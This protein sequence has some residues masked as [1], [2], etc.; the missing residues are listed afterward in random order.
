MLEQERLE[1]EAQER[2][3]YER[4]YIA[5][6]EKQ[7]KLLKESQNL[8]RLAKEERKCAP[9]PQCRRT[10]SEW[11]GHWP[12]H[13]WNQMPKSTAGSLWPRLNSLLSDKD[14]PSGN[15]SMISTCNLQ[16]CP[17]GAPNV[18][19]MMRH[20]PSEWYRMKALCFFLYFVVVVS[21]FFMLLS[22]Y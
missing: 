6:V 4:E 17:R 9:P 2:L 13:C 19:C 22:F 21:I 3:L 5:K 20:R 12:L 1:R 10:V 16:I 11:F 18:Y 15:L 7:R 14:L 8:E